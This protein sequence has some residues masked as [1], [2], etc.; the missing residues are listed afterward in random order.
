MDTWS[1]KMVLLKMVRSYYCCPTQN[2][3]NTAL[4]ILGEFKVRLPDGRL[5]ITSYQADDKGFRPKISYEVDPLFVPPPEEPVIPFTPEK[6]FIKRPPPQ[7][8][9]T[10]PTSY[11]PPLINY[12]PRGKEHS[13]YVTPA[14]S[15]EV[16]KP[17]YQAPRTEYKA[18]QPA[19]LYSPPSPAPYSPPPSKIYQIPRH[20]YSYEAPIINYKPKESINYLPPKREHLHNYISDEMYTP[21][22]RHDNPEVRAVFENEQSNDFRN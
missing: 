6:K 9:D 21:I 16:P 5:Q 1:S 10:V 8:Y 17:A 13:S 12:D 22:E 2:C 3:F 15:Y 20:D 7:A 18:P 11:L 14:P 19:T 4:P